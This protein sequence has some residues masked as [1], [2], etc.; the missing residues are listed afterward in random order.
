MLVGPAD[1]VPS[2]GAQPQ[3]R[4][5]V[6]VLLTTTVDSDKVTA[7]SDIV[8][9]DSDRGG[10]TVIFNRNRRSRSLG[11]GGHFQSECA[12]TLAR[13]TQTELM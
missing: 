10:K 12:V 2:L 7:N 1:V 11:I 3:E 13:N 4:G 5:A 9:A 6:R 8:T